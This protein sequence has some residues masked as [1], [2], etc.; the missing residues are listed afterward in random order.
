[1]S[2][3]P[4]SDRPTVVYLITNLRNGKRYVG[5]TS[6]RLKARFNQHCHHAWNRGE[7]SPLHMAIR[8][9]GREN[10][11][12]E[13]YEKCS[14]WTKALCRE[15]ELIAVLCP[16]YNATKGGEGAL[17]RVVSE[18]TRRK[19]SGRVT[20]KEVRE[21]LSQLGKQN[22]EE[23]RKYSHLGPMTSAKRVVCLDDGKEYESASAAGLAYGLPKSLV[24]EVCLRK[25]PRR[26]AGGLVFRYFGDHHG[27]KAEANAERATSYENRTRHQKNLKKSVVCVT[28]GR[29]FVGAEEASHAYGIHRSQIAAVCNGR[30]NHT[31]GK[32]FR[33][34]LQS[35]W[36]GGC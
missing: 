9:Y 3:P 23:W 19:M 28:D 5:I 10:F 4:A 15:V 29:R 31:H 11:T 22:I 6:C 20:T 27:G 30:R 13:V 25:P 34:E 36:A 2:R 8:K 35:N 18:E 33:Y 26:T 1:M 32:V 17:G 14:S 16:E 21:R 12:I 7:R 24:I